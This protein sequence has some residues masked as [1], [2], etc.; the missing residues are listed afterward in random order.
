VDVHL[1]VFSGTLKLPNL[2]FL[3]RTRWKT[4]SKLH[5]TEERLIITADLPVVNDSQSRKRV[6]NSTE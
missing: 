4:Y 2:G 3:G 6:Q 5:L 1:W